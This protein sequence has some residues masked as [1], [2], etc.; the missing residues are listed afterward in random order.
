[1]TLPFDKIW[2]VDFE[3]AAAPGESPVPI[4]LVALEYKSGRRSI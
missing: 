3:F 1:M 4:C 2:L